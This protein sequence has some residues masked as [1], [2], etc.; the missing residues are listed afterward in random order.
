MANRYYKLIIVIALV[1][2]VYF[3]INRG[4]V[5]PDQLVKINDHQPTSLNN[6][7]MLP[8]A[9]LIVV[10]ISDALA[11]VSKKPFGIK[12]SPS[13][14]PVS[15]EKFSGYHTGTDFETSEAEKDIAVAIFAICDGKLLVKKQASGY[16]GLIVQSCQLD[17][18]AITVVYG[19]VSLTSVSLVLGDNIKVGQSIALLGKGFSAE[20][21]GERKHL[22]LSVHLGSEVNILG[23]VAKPEELRNWLD[24]LTLLKN[25]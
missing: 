13:D 6:T 23:Y 12:I 17:K 2:G 8:V 24:P 14:S 18:Q 15:P 16:G 3:G 4:L 19:H 22:H 9:N 7:N 1:V 5:V 10:P 20:T 21:D 25:N 11:R